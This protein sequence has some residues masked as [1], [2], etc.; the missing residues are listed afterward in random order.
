MV[1]VNDIGL[2]TTDEAA[3]SPRITRRDDGSHCQCS[4]PYPSEARDL[5]VRASVGLDLHSGVAEQR[6][7]TLYSA[8]NT[9]HHA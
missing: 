1:D 4:P 5:I 2:E 6:D 3:E 7:V 9:R 8:A